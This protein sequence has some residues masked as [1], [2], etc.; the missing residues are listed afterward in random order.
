MSLDDWI[1]ELGHQLH[2]AHPRRRVPGAAIAALVAIACAA[3][4]A[5][6]IPHPE[7][8][9]EVPARPPAA[10][11]P[12]V[13]PGTVL[14]R[15][16][17]G[18]ACPKPNNLSCDRVGIYAELRRP[19]RGVVAEIAG[20]RLPLDDPH[21]SSAP[22]AGL[23]RAFAGFLRS[24]GLRRPGP[25]HFTATHETSVRVRF[26]LTRADGSQV[27]TSLTVGLSAGWG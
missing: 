7:A 14:R 19:A 18:V 17:M 12:E 15:T 9:D 10:T 26:V 6:A 8:G 23:R 3:A 27:Q 2:A 16:Y 4:I 25:L 1:D 11:P 24:A 5:I 22:K 21:W 20:R 13:A